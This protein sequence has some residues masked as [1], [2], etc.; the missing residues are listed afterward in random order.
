MASVAACFCDE[1][2][3][4]CAVLVGAAAVAAAAVADE[5]APGVGGEAAGLPL[6]DEAGVGAAADLFCV[7]FLRTVLSAL[8]ESSIGV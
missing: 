7:R 6:V 1:P 4:F 5:C 8:S 3:A 2:T